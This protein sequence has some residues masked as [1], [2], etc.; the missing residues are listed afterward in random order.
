MESNQTSQHKNYNGN[1]FW[2]FEAV[3]IVNKDVN[4][5]IPIDTDKFKQFEE[6]QFYDCIVFNED[7][8]DSLF[9]QL[10]DSLYEYFSNDKC[11]LILKLILLFEKRLKL[12]RALS[13]AQN[14]FKFKTELPAIKGINVKQSSKS[15][16]T[17]FKRM[18]SSMSSLTET[19]YANLLLVYKDNSIR[20]LYNYEIKKLLFYLKFLPD[21]RKLK[22]LRLFPI[23]IKQ[24]DFKFQTFIDKED[25]FSETKED[26][27]KKTLVPKTREEK[28]FESFVEKLKTIFYEKYSLLLKKLDIQ[29]F[30]LN[31]TVYLF[32]VKEILFEKY[33]DKNIKIITERKLM[34][35][36][37]NHK[38]KNLKIN[39]DAPNLKEIKQFFFTMINVYD[40]TKK[41]YKLDKYLKIPPKDETTDNVFKILRP[42]CPYSYSE[43]IEDNVSKK[44]FAKYASSNLWNV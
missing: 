24:L 31:N 25:K 15:G 35:F 37:D 8:E 16:N 3:K 27:L 33:D 26:I 40:D 28:L 11:E 10:E 17:K 19:I 6:I 18:A 29:T 21:S 20:W 22:M 14:N 39:K 36:R 9:V 32:D 30:E 42:G 23:D 44:N 13:I 2:I 1:L 43:L 34:T 4:L 41:H 5:D 7:R 38:Y 12:Y